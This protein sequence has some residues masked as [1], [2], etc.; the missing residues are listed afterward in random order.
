MTWSPHVT[1]AAVIER[2]G[3]FLFVEELAGGERVYNQP[4]GHLEP[5][6]S[7]I[8][9]VVRETLEETAARFTPSALLGVYRWV[10][11]RK[12]TTFLRFTF[13]GTCSEPDP[14]RELDDGILGTVWLSRE[15]LAA[16]PERLRS[17]LVLQNVDDF[18]N[19]RT[20]PLELLG[21]LG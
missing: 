21:D 3:R 13:A 1:V 10:H 12:G 4:A 7:L 19:G 2:Q 14:D 17:A 6:E 20:Y 16:S 9:A 15:E 5:G 8:E 18:L 11:P